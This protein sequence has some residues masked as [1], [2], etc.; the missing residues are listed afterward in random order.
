MNKQTGEKNDNNINY[1]KFVKGL[2]SYCMSKSN[3]FIRKKHQ[4]KTQEGAGHL[5][6][7]QDSM[8]R[9]GKC[10]LLCM[11]IPSCESAPNSNLTKRKKK[12]KSCYHYKTEID[13]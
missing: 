4:S 13:E 12:K 11:H 10:F 5:N 1:K 6:M 3:K 7:E 9:H 8:S 2:N